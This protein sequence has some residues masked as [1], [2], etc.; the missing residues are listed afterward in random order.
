MDAAETNWKD[1]VTADRGDLIIDNNNIIII[2]KKT[3]TPHPKQTHYHNIIVDVHKTPT[4]LTLLNSLKLATFH[5]HHIL[6]TLLW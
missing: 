1:K 5:R 4:G 6:N 2:D 3:L